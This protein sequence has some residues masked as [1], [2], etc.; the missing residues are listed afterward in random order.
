MRSS[1]VNVYVALVGPP[2][3][4]TGCGSG[5]S[6]DVRTWIPECHEQRPGSVSTVRSP[7]ALTVPTITAC[8]SAS[9][10]RLA[11][12]HRVDPRGRH[13]AGHGHRHEG[14][15]RRLRR[16]PRRPCQGARSRPPQVLGPRALQRRPER[17]QG[18][19]AAQQA[20][21]QRREEP[22]RRGHGQEIAIEGREPLLEEQRRRHDQERL[23]DAEEYQLERRDR[24]DADA[25]RRPAKCPAREEPE[26]QRGA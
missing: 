25:V 10:G 26:E 15:P 9:T 1:R 8:V 3:S 4:S 18:T 13:R 6:G 7:V 12:Q 19:A 24:P 16:S 17:P 23:V 11:G 21:Q 5:S 2:F 22:Q 14:R 20:E